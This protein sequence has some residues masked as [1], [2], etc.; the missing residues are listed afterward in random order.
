MKKKKIKEIKN[1]HRIVELANERG[2]SLN[3]LFS[4]E[5]KYANPLFDQSGLLKKENKKCNLL[6]EM[7]KIL[8]KE[9]IDDIIGNVDNIHCVLIDVMLLFRKLSWKN[10]NSFGD[11][12]NAFCDYVKKYL[13]FVPNVKRIDFL[14]DSYFEKSVKNSERMRRKKHETINFYEINQMT[15]LPKQEN[16]FWPSNNNKILL[17]QLLRGHILHYGKNIWEGVEI[18][19]STANESVAFSNL[20]EHCCESFLQ[21]LQR[22]NIEEADLKV[23]VHINHILSSG[24]FNIFVAS[25]DTDV[26]VLLMHYWEHFY[27]NGAKVIRIIFI[28]NLLTA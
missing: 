27:N 11:L 17:Q 3:R 2:Y 23:I 12:V 4:F 28:I 24:I 13:H 21:N 14:F 5:L 10:L 15:K 16:K 9:N 22:S 20:Y 25:S 7:E 19:C 26:F 18:V 6:N 8:Q 1:I